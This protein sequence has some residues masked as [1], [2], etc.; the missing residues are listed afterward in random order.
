MRRG[1]GVAV[2][3]VVALVA[4]PG[5]V[6]AHGLDPADYRWVTP[7]AGV[8]ASTDP[9]EPRHAGV[10]RTLGA[11][12]VWT[13]DLQFSV[14]LAGGAYRDVEDL[15]VDLVPFDPAVFP[16]L[17]DGLDAVGNAYEVTF[18]NGRGG[19]VVPG[20]VAG[21]V[22]FSLPHRADGVFLL[23]AGGW[24]GSPVIEELTGES[25]TGAVVSFRGS[26]VY[27]AGV[28]HSD[29]RSS[30][31]ASAALSGALIVALAGLMLLGWRRSIG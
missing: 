2:A 13:P 14:D 17:P 24:A 3:I 7:P 12:S 26:G 19:P 8:E 15:W 16:P 29:G 31:L 9:P 23:D 25:G 27:L 22:R 20:A 28:E 4:R 11:A 5:L 18:R 10:L 21:S 6:A 1:A 30:L